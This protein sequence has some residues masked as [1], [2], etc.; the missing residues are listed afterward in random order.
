MDRKS[1]TGSILDESVFV[2]AHHLSPPAGHCV[3]VKRK[4]GIR[5]HKRFIYSGDHPVAAAF[6][7]GAQGVIKTEQVF[8]RFHER[9]T[10]GFK[11]GRENGTFPVIYIQHPVTNGKGRLY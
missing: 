8:V 7:A 3:L 5:D 10:V 1:G 4:F 11:T 2:L 9:D 6:R